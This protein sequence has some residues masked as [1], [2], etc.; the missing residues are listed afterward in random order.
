MK[1]RVVF[2]L[3]FS[4]AASYGHGGYEDLIFRYYRGSVKSDCEVKIGLQTDHTEGSSA[5]AYLLAFRVMIPSL[6]LFRGE[7]TMDG[8]V[9]L[10]LPAK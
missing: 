10:K 9:Y 8:L 1:C 4:I 5:D 7:N 3:I 6:I 2:L